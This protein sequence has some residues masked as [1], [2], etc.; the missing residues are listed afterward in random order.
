M[1]RLE[2]YFKQIAQPSIKMGVLAIA[3]N[4]ESA[5]Q[6][7]KTYLSLD[8]AIAIHPDI[9]LREQPFY[10][11]AQNT[12]YGLHHGFEES[13]PDAWGRAV[14]LRAKIP[15]TAYDILRTIGFDTMGAFAFA[16]EGRELPVVANLDERNY[17]DVQ[18]LSELS[19][20]I[21]KQKNILA[22]V[23]KRLVQSSASPGGARPKALV[24]MDGKN[25]LAKF[26]SREDP[27]DIISME[28]D[29][30]SVMEKLDIPVPKHQLIQL[31][32]GKN[33]LAMERFDLQDNNFIPMLSMQSLLQ[34]SASDEGSYSDCLDV[35]KKYS[36]SPVEDALNLYKQMVVNVG[37]ANTDD[38]LK[39]FSMLYL[40]SS[41]YLSPA[42][43]VTPAEVFNIDKSCPQRHS[44][45]FTNQ[46]DRIATK[47]SLLDIAKLF[48]VSKKRAEQIV[49]EIFELTEELQREWNISL[50]STNS[51][52]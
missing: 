33:V 10:F 19:E 13:L 7:N 31:D 12:N 20:K 38:H 16:E 35:I 34:R 41:W 17:F 22:K 21:E 11:A 15:N 18:T 8:S 32:N 26:P 47:E 27:V 4:R 42:Y 43:D 52:L 30:L 48:G 2:V 50:M 40:N 28:Y 46:D 3:D 39:N 6:Y 37:V 23:L 1:G 5:F 49:T 44:I 45:G 51:N 36:G 24:S 14:A 29:C 25:Y 9:P